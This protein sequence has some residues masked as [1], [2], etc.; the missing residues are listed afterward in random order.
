METYQRPVKNDI[1]YSHTP[2]ILNNIYP[3]KWDIQ[4]DFYNR[5]PD[6]KIHANELAY[7]YKKNPNLSLDAVY[8]QLR[9]HYLERGYDFNTPLAEIVNKTQTVDNR[10]RFN[11]TNVNQNVKTETI[12]CVVVWF[13]FFFFKK[14]RRIHLMKWQRILRI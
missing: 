6:A 8:Y 9:N 10:S 3:L 13:F 1:S 4:T 2:I 5:Y 14:I 11:T 12:L 7:L